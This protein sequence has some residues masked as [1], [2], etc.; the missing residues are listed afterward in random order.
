[1]HPT[2]QPTS[3]PDCHSWLA[4]A[5]HKSRLRHLSLRSGV[6]FSTLQ[7]NSQIRAL[8]LQPLMFSGNPLSSCGGPCRSMVC[9]VVEGEHEV[10]EHEIQ[11]DA[12]FGE[13]GAQTPGGCTSGVVH[14]SVLRVDASARSITLHQK[15]NIPQGN[16]C[17]ICAILL[18]FVMTSLLFW[19]LVRL[20]LDIDLGQ[21]LTGWDIDVTGWDSDMTGTFCAAVPATEATCEG[22][23]KKHCLGF[24]V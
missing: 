5:A 24:M 13:E 18:F 16:P 8:R 15:L 22:K 4:A 23:S 7:A 9:V 21:W 20:A 10:Q 17:T 12:F 19:R 2:L 3:A 14:Q 6:R 1:M 11:V